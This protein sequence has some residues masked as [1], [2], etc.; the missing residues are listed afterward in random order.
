MTG[1]RR[2]PRRTNEIAIQLESTTRG[3]L[4]E[5]PPFFEFLLATLDHSRPVLVAGSFGRG[6]SLANGGFDL[7]EVG[8][9]GGLVSLR[10][11]SESSCSGD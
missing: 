9:G 1:A 10:G 2:Q 4:L 11:G 6:F 3:A 7:T 8:S 5:S